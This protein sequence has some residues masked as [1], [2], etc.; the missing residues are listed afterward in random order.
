VTRPVFGLDAAGQNSDVDVQT[1]MMMRRRGYLVAAVLL[2]VWIMPL[3]AQVGRDAAIAKAEAVLK[4]LQDG[5]TA[6][7]VKEFDDRMSKE[8]PEER[9]KPVWSALV[10]QFGAFKNITERREGQVR[11]RQ[12]VELILEFEK[13]TIVNRTAFDNAGRLTGLEFRPLE[14]ALLPANK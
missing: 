4:N 6:D 12:A 14:M 13:Q 11:G 7:V 8:L 1:P 10:T 2:S 3:A 5:K 9:L